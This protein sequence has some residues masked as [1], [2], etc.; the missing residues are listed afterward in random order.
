[1]SREPHERARE[2]LLG[3][4][5]SA[6]DQRWLEEHLAGCTDCR[7][8]LARTEEVRRALRGLGLGAAAGMAERT[9]LRVRLYR[10][11]LHERTQRQWLL[12]G[13]VGL[14]VFSSWL[15][16]PALWIAARWAAQLA[17]VASPVGVMAFFAAWTL[18]A[19]LAA[20]AAVAV[21][22]QANHAVTSHVTSRWAGGGR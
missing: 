15:L 14:A 1:M 2:L 9:K 13:A 17:G 22:R 12:T 5:P 6:A 19:V 20:A 11:E 4:P 3:D 21:R 10:E 8:L 16:A 7:D 18:P